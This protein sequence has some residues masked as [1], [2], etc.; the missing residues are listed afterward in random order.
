MK[1]IYKFKNTRKGKR[2]WPVCSKDEGVEQPQKPA[3]KR[4]KPTKHHRFST[5]LHKMDPLT[6]DAYESSVH[7]LKAE[8]ME[9]KHPK[10]KVIK[11]LLDDTLIQRRKWI[12]EDQPHVADII[13]R[14]PFFRYERWVSNYTSSFIR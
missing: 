9:K 4:S 5:E 7:Q 14:F 11:K 12:T 8:L 2:K 6:D 13:D 3:E 10:S 1:I